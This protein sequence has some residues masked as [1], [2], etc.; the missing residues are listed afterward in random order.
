M[1]KQIAAL[2]THT[3]VVSKRTFDRFTAAEKSKLLCSSLVDLDSEAF[4]SRLAEIKQEGARCPVEQ[5]DHRRKGRAHDRFERFLE[6]TTLFGEDGILQNMVR[7]QL[8]YL[9]ASFAELPRK[10]LFDS[11]RKAVCKPVD[12]ISDFDTGDLDVEE[13]AAALRF[14]GKPLAQ[15]PDVA[16]WAT[17]MTSSEPCSQWASADSDAREEAVKT[18]RVINFQIIDWLHTAD[19]VEAL[20]RM[21]KFSG[22]W[23]GPVTSVPFNGP[24]VD[25]FA[26]WFHSKLYSTDALYITHTA[27]PRFRIM[28]RASL[29]RL[30]SCELAYGSTQRAD[31]LASLAA[32]SG[33]RI[34]QHAPPKDAMQ[35]IRAEAEYFALRDDW[36]RSTSVCE[37]CDARDM[38]RASADLIVPLSRRHLRGPAP[39]PS[40]C[41]DITDEAFKILIESQEQVEKHAEEE[42]LRRAAALNRSA[43]PAPDSLE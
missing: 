28:R 4:E 19:P 2:D 7:L 8:A 12:E 35:A 25:Q 33:Q 32:R 17:L 31:R 9:P 6:A 27:A 39:K 18:G 41:E 38:L 5:R 14:L 36:R 34:R 37:R 40:Y 26:A 30:A 15:D 24:G 11:L 13:L 23:G 3:P 29:F 42:A 10:V 20:E 43:G 22:T 16:A 21:Q 1:D